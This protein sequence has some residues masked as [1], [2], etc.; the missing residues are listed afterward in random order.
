MVT[1]S[2]LVEAT[3]LPPQPHRLHPLQPVAVAYGWLRGG[4]FLGTLGT[5][6][7]APHS[8]AGA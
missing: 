3:A 6:S 4:Q 2:C 5:G 7:S 1:T 8:V